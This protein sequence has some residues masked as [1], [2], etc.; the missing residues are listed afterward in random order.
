MTGGKWETFKEDIQGKS[1]WYI[2]RKVFLHFVYFFKTYDRRKAKA[3]RLRQYQKVA[4]ALLSKLPGWK[5][6]TNKKYDRELIVS[7]TT[8]PG[9]IAF[10]SNATK[11]LLLQNRKPNRL[12]LWLAESQFPNKEAD[13]PKELVDQCRYGL[14]IRWCE[15]LRSYKKLIPALRA[16]PEAVIVTTDDDTYYQRS[17]L[18]KLHNAYRKDPDVI[19]AHA[20]SI[21]MAKD[22]ALVGR[23]WISNPEYLRFWD[24]SSVK[25]RSMAQYARIPTFLNQAIGVSGALYPPH[26]LH[27]D[28]LQEDR[29]MTLCPTNDDIWFWLMAARA[30]KRTAVPKRDYYIDYTV[31]GTQSVDETLYWINERGG[32]FDRDFHHL[33]KEYP[34]VEKTLLEEFDRVIG[35][36]G[37]MTTVKFNHWRNSNH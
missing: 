8:Y 30:G 21:F 9:R 32:V 13:L 27:P 7:L 26:S 33:L 18:R 16:F 34:E 37:E 19:W 12:I 17:M 1:F 15:D 25:I 6:T 29:F 20:V 10:V 5:G 3:F 24:R 4:F 2:I 11:S 28:V 35:S 23:V 31:D 36:I 14:E 22:G